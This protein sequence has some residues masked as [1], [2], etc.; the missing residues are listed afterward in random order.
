MRV[1]RVRRGTLESRFWEKVQR[2][3]ATQCWPWTGAKNPH[4]Y[5]KMFREGE[6]VDAHRLS[7]E[8]NRGEIPLGMCV[9]H[10]CD[11]PPCVNPLHLFLGTMKDNMDDKVRKGHERNQN[12][13]KRFCIRGHNL[14]THGYTNPNRGNRYCRICQAASAAKWRERVARER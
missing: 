12:T 8:I 4:G 13:G 6:I 7:Y 9:C 10:T 2:G 11:N 14:A 5:G 3:E 1:I